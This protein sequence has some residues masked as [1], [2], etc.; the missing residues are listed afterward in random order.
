MRVLLVEDEKR[1]ASL[2]AEGLGDEG[3][4][5]DIEEDGAAGLWRATEGSYDAI[6]LDIMLPEQNGWQVCAALREQNDWTPVL[7]LTAKNGDF[8]E[9]DSLD[10]GADDFLRK[11][12]SLV[13]LLARLRALVRRGA[14]PRPAVLTCGEISFDPATRVV[15]RG[16]VIVELTPREMDLLEMLMRADGLPVPKKDILDRVWGFDAEPSSN[17]VEVYVRYL[18]QKLDHPFGG[19]AHVLTVR[20]SGYRMATEAAA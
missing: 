16:E 4:T 5:V 1:L 7:M 2:V 14:P 19:P 10:N 11:P 15:R 18:R 6:I 8:D 12:F 13:V 20:G 3:V 9:A 17:V